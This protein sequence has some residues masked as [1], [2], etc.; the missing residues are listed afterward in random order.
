[1]DV[2]SDTETCH[3]ELVMRNLICM[4]IAK[5]EHREPWFD[6]EGFVT[7]YALIL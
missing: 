2:R 5:F 6:H 7:V 3:S 4:Q 1:M